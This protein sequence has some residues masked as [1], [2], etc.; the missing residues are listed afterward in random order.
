MRSICAT[1]CCSMPTLPCSWLPLT[2]KPVPPAVAIRTVKLPHEDG[3]RGYL[4]SPGAALSHGWVSMANFDR[5]GVAGDEQDRSF[6]GSRIRGG[7]STKKVPA[8]LDV[9]GPRH[10]WTTEAPCESGMGA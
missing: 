2:A 10:P 4:A 3:S 7:Q 6:G 1:V 5:T 9:G 8:A